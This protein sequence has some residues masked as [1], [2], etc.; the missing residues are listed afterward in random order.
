MV[1]VIDDG[2]GGHSFP[3]LVIGSVVIRDGG[4][5]L[6]AMVVKSAG[7]HYRIITLCTTVT[8]HDK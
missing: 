8:V 7:N 3:I 5:P 6:W 4:H 2:A 1:V